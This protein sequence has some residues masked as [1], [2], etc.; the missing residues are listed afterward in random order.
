[1]RPPRLITRIE[2]RRGYTLVEMLVVVTVFAFLLASVAL[3]MGTLFR[4]QGELQD[5]L[6]QAATASRLA[7]QLRADAHLAASA[8]VVQEGGT[9]GPLLTLPH[10]TV[11]YRTY[12]RRIVRTVMQD[13]SETHR[14]VFPLPEGTTARW[15]LSS[16]TPAFI[17]LT[18]SYW[19]PGMREGVARPREHRVEAS[20]GL[21]A[22]GV[23]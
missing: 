18:T 4:A 9:P 11:I 2:R 16:G 5:E 13:D 3:A 12:P 23:R 6:A 19:P 21:H 1:M 7:S 17:T 20:I 10:A 15:E 8:F 14:E 22:G